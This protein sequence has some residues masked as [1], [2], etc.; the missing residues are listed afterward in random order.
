MERIAGVTS[1]DST[2]QPGPPGPIGPTGARGAPGL[3]G[4]PGPPGP[5]G[6]VFETFNIFNQGRD[7]Q[8]REAEPPKDIF[9]VKLSEE[10]RRL[11]HQANDN[12]AQAQKLLSNYQ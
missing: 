6:K 1:E 7:D 12:V 5:Q 3:P 11:I 8:G 4:P 10:A 2:P 9:D